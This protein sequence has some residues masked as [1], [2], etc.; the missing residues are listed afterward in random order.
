MPR[1]KGTK[2]SKRPGISSLGWNAQTTEWV[3]A[4]S[5]GLK[6]GDWTAVRDTADRGCEKDPAANK[7]ENNE[8]RHFVSDAAV[9][10]FGSMSG[11]ALHTR[12]YGA[13]LTPQRSAIL[14][15]FQCLCAGVCGVCRG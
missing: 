12:V 3:L 1:N 10:A 8:T 5:R 11:I 6:E 14:H 15:L 2:S 4:G 13:A 9:L 7:E